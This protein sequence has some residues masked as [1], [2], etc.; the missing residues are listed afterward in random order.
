MVRS[1]GRLADKAGFRAIA[2]DHGLSGYL[3]HCQKLATKTVN[4][5]LSVLVASKVIS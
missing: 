2:N 5:C 1:P 3:I 4:L